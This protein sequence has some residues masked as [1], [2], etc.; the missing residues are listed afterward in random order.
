MRARTSRVYTPKSRTA[1]AECIDTLSAG[2]KGPLKGP[3]SSRDLLMLSSTAIWALLFKQ[4]DTK[5]KEKKP[6]GLVDEILG[7][8]PLLRPL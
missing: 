6:I 2:V 1:G 5:S 7:G 4:S 3:G 8:A